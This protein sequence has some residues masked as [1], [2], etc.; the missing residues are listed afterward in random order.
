MTQIQAPSA[1]I[2]GVLKDVFQF[3]QTFSNHSIALPVKDASKLVFNFEIIDLALRAYGLKGEVI[4]VLK[5]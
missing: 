5:L 2:Y 4:G 1:H 3:I